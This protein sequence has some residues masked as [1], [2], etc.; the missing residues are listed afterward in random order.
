MASFLHSTLIKKKKRFVERNVGFLVNK[1][2]PNVILY[3]TSLHQKS[4]YET[5]CILSAQLSY[6]ENSH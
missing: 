4:F 3:N 5:G 1:S 2:W 6:L